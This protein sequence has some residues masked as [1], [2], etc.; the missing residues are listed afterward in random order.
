[1]TVIV[2]IIGPDGDVYMGG[3]SA[4]TTAGGSQSVY[5][6]K[7][8]FTP[9]HGPHYLMGVCGNHRLSQVMRYSFVPP[10]PPGPDVDLE[11]FMASDFVN[12][13]RK[14]YKDNGILTS[15]EDG[16]ET[17]SFGSFLVGYQGRLFEMEENF[18]ILIDRRNYMA[19]GS[20]EDLALGALYATD[21]PGA[22]AVERIKTAI[23]AAVTF[24]AWCREPYDILRLPFDPNWFQ[25][26]RPRKKASGK[27]K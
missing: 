3:D 10:P 2:G 23:K 12:S 17:G 4:A 5:V 9:V 27:G 14:C 8:V 15:T 1:M 22:D 21:S 20:G 7:K 19:V 13:V 26:K 11:Q 25:Q 6:N 16:A 18:Q 24:S